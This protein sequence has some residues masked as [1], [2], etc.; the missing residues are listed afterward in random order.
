VTGLADEEL[1][2]FAARTPVEPVVDLPRMAL[3]DEVAE[4]YATT[5]LSLK[6]HPMA[7]LRPLLA[8]DRVIPAQAL[9][10]ATPGRHVAVA[11]LVLVRQRPGSASGTIFMTIEDET[12]IANLIVWPAVYEAYRRAVLGSALVTAIGRVQ[13]EAK[14]VHLV[15]EKLIDRGAILARLRTLDEQAGEMPPSRGAAGLPEEF[16]RLSRDFR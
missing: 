12:G 2:L 1:P 10:T 13:R 11:G 6:R 7:L 14:V 9:A 4:D 8:S 5:G 16:R 3:G 15:V